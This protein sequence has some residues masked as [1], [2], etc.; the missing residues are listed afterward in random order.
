MADNITIRS[1]FV[2][3]QH[4]IPGIIPSELFNRKLVYFLHH[5]NNLSDNN[6][7]LINGQLPA[8]QQLSY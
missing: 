4:H 6:S 7:Y 1:H 5:V 8:V 2:L 3:I